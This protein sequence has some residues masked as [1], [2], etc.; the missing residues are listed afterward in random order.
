M[1]SFYQWADIPRRIQL[2]ITVNAPR[3][4]GCHERGQQWWLCPYHIG[5]MDGWEAFE[6]VLTDTEPRAAK[7]ER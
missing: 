4:C 6:M 7:G 2:S 3:N 5:M 1:S